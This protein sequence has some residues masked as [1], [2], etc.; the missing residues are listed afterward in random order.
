[1][2]Q[3]P[4][5]FFLGQKARRQ[6]S[7]AQATGAEADWGWGAPGRAERS[8][9]RGHMAVPLSMTTTP[10]AA[11]A[12]RMARGPSRP[13]ARA[14]VKAEAAVS[15][16]PETS[17]T[18]SEPAARMP[19]P[20]G[21]ARENRAMPRFPMVE[22]NLLWCVGVGANPEVSISWNETILRNR[23]YVVRALMS[24][25]AE[26]VFITRV[27]ARPKL[28]AVLVDE[29]I[30]PHASTLVASLLNTVVAYTP[31]GLMP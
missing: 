31:K 25:L 26:E 29:S 4:G 10:E 9:E 2:G 18:D 7:F 28:R 20:S 8:F 15:P 30:C 21:C 24:C 14:R 6:P 23:G 3:V 16:A 17:M 11:S 12:K 5:Q 1:M 13:A 27:G 19:T 22:Y